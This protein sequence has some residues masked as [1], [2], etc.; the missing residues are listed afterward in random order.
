MRRKRPYELQMERIN[1]WQNKIENIIEDY[2]EGQLSEEPLFL[3]D[4]ILTFFTCCDHIKDYII[5]DDVI[6]TEQIPYEYIN[7]N[8]CL[9]ICRDI[10]VG[11]KHLKID[12][13]KVPGGRFKVNLVTKKDKET[14]ELS[15]D[16]NL[17][18]K[19]V[20]ENFSALANKCIQAWKHYIEKEIESKPK[21]QV[22][23]KCPSCKLEFNVDF[24]L[25]MTDCPECG[26]ER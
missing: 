18:S 5:N 15:F 3:A 6:D 13:P 11:T 10:S 2:K 1:R 24:D 22:I 14:G 7:E 16:V 21:R 4:M 25:I 19:T 26:Q 12:N 8:D 9:K 20:K 17:K 23:I